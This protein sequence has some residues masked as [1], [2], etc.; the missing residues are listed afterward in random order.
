MEWTDTDFFGVEYEYSDSLTLD[1]I[2]NDNCSPLG[3]TYTFKSDGT[4]DDRCF[5]LSAIEN[6]ADFTAALF[7]G[8]FMND[9]ILE[10]NVRCRHFGEQAGDSQMTF[11]GNNPVSSSWCKYA[12][13][14]TIECDCI[15]GETYGK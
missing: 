11:Y 3:K 2:D 10:V 5:D 13:E 7:D 15:R 14:V 4:S 1:D 9:H 8:F 12:L 6:M